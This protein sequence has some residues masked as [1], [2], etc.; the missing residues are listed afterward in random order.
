MKNHLLILAS[1]LALT[2]AG[3]A[4]PHHGAY[5]PTDASKYD[6][7]GK[8]KAVL[9]DPGAKH[10]VSFTGIQETTLP[11]GRLKVLPKFLNLENRRIQVQVDCVF[12]D[13]Q[14]FPVDQTAFRNL[15]L[16][17]NSQEAV[18]FVSLNDKAKGYVIR[19]REAR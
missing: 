17:E 13:E 3:C 14:G 8:L 7:E 2:V 9:L 5:A 15:I 1:A 11:D 4:S 6:Q 19:V 12:K 16:T 10:S 18:E